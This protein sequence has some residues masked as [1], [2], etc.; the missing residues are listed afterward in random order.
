MY[1][2]MYDTFVL[3]IFI[4][5]CTLVCSFFVHRLGNT[6]YRRY[7]ICHRPCRQH[8]FVVHLWYLSSHLPLV[9]LAPLLVHMLYVWPHVMF[10]FNMT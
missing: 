1:V 4:F 2:M 7:A 9:A 10:F 8:L 6:V 3:F 5:L